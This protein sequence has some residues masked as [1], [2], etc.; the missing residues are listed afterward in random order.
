V[1]VFVFWS[2][3]P[4]MPQ[5]SALKHWTQTPRPEQSG[6]PEFVQSRAKLHSTHCPAILQNGF[7]GSE[8]SEALRHWTHIARA[9][10]QNGVAPLHPEFAVQPLVHWRAETLHTRPLAQS[11]DARQATQRPNVTSQTGF[12]AA[13]PV[14]Q[15]VPTPGGAPPEPVFPAIPPMSAFDESSPLHA[16]TMAVTEKASAQAKCLRKEAKGMG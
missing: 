16:A 4:S 9:A 12:G 5:S 2:H 8:Q 7:A 11:L 13:H 10:S 15:F 6:L 3:V 1:H 14:A